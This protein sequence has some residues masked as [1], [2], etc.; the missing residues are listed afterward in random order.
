MVKS[1]GN[2]SR[3]DALGTRHGLSI[4][5]LSPHSLAL[6]LSLLLYLDQRTKYI[7]IAVSI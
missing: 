5:Q 1:E 4:Q 2:V 7:E 6:I 3:R